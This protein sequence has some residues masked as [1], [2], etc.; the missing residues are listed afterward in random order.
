MGNRFGEDGGWEEVCRYPR[1][2]AIRA[3]FR[4]IQLKILHRAYYTRTR[5]FA[6]EKTEHDRFLGRFGQK[7]TLLHTLWK[8]PKL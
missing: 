3:G 8:C 2:V 1:E 7:G 6:M 5:V 4:L